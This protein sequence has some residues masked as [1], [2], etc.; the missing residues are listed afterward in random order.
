MSRNEKLS[1]SIRNE[2][3]VKSKR[4]IKIST[5]KTRIFK[6]QHLLYRCTFLGNDHVS[7]SP[8]VFNDQNKETGCGNWDQ[9]FGTGVATFLRTTASRNKLSLRVTKKKLGYKL[10]LSRPVVRTIISS[11]NLDHQSG[12][13][14]C[15]GN[16]TVLKFQ[17]VTVF[18]Y[19]QS[20][21]CKLSPRFVV[22]NGARRGPQLAWLIV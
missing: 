11:N 18:E 19:L 12:S 10:C 7:S 16:V 3:L 20:A 14:R 2:V 13:C 8:S 4:S 22:T 21:K 17:F 15:T 6:R 5:T 9:Y 1:F